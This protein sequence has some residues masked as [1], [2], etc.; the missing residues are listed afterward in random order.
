MNIL[1]TGAGRG[2]GLALARGAL[3]RGHAVVATVRRIEDG[4]GLRT[5]GA[6]IELYDAEDPVGADTLAH[7]LRD[8]ALDVLVNNAGVM[9]ATEPLGAITL[10]NLR[11][12]FEVDAAAP[13]L[14][15]QALLANLRAGGAKR[16]VHVTSRMGS[17]GD[18]TSGGA[19][20]YRAAKAAL[21][22]V[23]MSLTRDLAGAGFVCVAMHP[24]WVR[25]AMGGSAAPLDTEAA[26]EQMLNTILA[27]EGCDHGRFLGPDG[28][29]IPW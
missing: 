21:N 27:L 11:H 16:I 8:L 23:H 15:T 25:T 3:N 18:N 22:A 7:V 10:A 19:Y 24:G 20:A 2:I 28:S 12:V 9:G 17:I 26:A 6:R 5:L 4:A 14:L 29:A 1:I 13:L